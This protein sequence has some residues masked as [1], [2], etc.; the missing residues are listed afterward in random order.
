[1]VFL[2]Y[3]LLILSSFGPWGPNSFP[4]SFFAFL[5]PSPNIFEGVQE[6][7]SSSFPILTLWRLWAGVETWM[8][9]GSIFQGLLLLPLIFPLFPPLRMSFLGGPSLILRALGL[10]VK[11]LLFAAIFTGLPQYGIDTCLVL[12]DTMW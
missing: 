8:F 10:E 11:T 2:R 12:R 7:L 6:V 1:M 3:C 9:H 5:R 4:S